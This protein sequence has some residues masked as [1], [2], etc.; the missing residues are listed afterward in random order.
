MSFA[1]GISR[2]IP[3]RSATRTLDRQCRTTPR[4]P[5]APNRRESVSA[6]AR[7]G[8]GLA[9]GRGEEPAVDTVGLGLAVGV[10]IVAVGVPTSGADTPPPVP[11]TSD[12]TPAASFA[13]QYTPRS[14][15]WH[16]PLSPTRRQRFPALS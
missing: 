3:P 1:S 5:S 11:P 15:R 13:R 4:P 12:L 10:D 7:G 16:S 8:L 6:E 2:N 14:S 9:E